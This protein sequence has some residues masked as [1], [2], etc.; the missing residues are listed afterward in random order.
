MITI[1]DSG[2]RAVASGILLILVLSACSKEEPRPSDPRRATD[3]L[4]I[5]DIDSSPRA[6]D[7]RSSKASHL[8]TCLKRKHEAQVTKME[9]PQLSEGAPSASV[10][11]EL[12]RH[13]VE[14][15]R[16]A[17]AIVV[18]YRN[19][20]AQACLQAGVREK[21]KL[22]VPVGVGATVEHWQLGEDYLLLDVRE[23]DDVFVR[24]DFGGPE[25]R[26]YSKAFAYSS[27]GVDTTRRRTW[28]YGPLGPDLPRP[29]VRFKGPI[30]WRKL[31]MS[32]YW[33]P[34]STLPKALTNG[35]SKLTAGSLSPSM[36]LENPG[37]DDFPYLIYGEH[38]YAKILQRVDT[39]WTFQVDAEHHFVVSV[40]P[41]SGM[42]VKFNGNGE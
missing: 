31:E 39:E 11:V 41:S 5:P 33:R 14:E 4:G 27:F 1:L 22:L 28:R 6:G 20:T 36:V 13:H 16:M 9:F 2:V 15:K 19:G 10:S 40:K 32:P 3:A 29:T 25:W 42:R 26:V 37:P 12:S 35:K 30:D 17:K 8:R 34:S 38:D 18:I 23:G 21:V 7:P 24:Y